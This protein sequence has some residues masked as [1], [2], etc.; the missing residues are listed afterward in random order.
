MEQSIIFGLIT[1]FLGLILGHRLSLGRDKRKE[2]NEVS[3]PIRHALLQQIAILESGRTANKISD[4]DFIQLGM[5][6]NFWKVSC[7]RKTLV[8][9]KESQNKCGHTGEDGSFVIDNL[10]D[11]IKQSHKLLAYVPI[12]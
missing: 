2:F 3:T 4:S 8:A 9:Y 11:Y 5:Y 7:Y 1:F 12:K 10:S 6:L